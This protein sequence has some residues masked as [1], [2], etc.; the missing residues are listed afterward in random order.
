MIETGATASV[1]HR[2]ALLELGDLFSDL[3]GGRHEDDLN[4]IAKSWEAENPFPE[5]DDVSD[6]ELWEWSGRREAYLI[7][8]KREA[9][10][11]LANEVR[12]FSDSRSLEDVERQAQEEARQIKEREYAQSDVAKDFAAAEAQRSSRLEA[13]D[14]RKEAQR[15][16]D[17]ISQM[18]DEKI[19][20]EYGKEAYEWSNKRYESLRQDIIQIIRQSEAY[21]LRMKQEAW[22]DKKLLLEEEARRARI[23]FKYEVGRLKKWDDEGGPKSRIDRKKYA[24]FEE[25]RESVAI[26]LEKAEKKLKTWL[27]NNP[28]PELEA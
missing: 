20:R 12:S 24:A 23:D 22:D 14:L 18:A 27:E 26:G 13:Q 2:Y 17:R 7:R 1:A 15:Q 4:S 9:I 16:R 19:I 11:V 5:G 28:R 3:E 10:E 21:V 6:K 25:V 8:R